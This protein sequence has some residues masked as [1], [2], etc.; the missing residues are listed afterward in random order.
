[1]CNTSFS[2]SL[3]AIFILSV[4]ETSRR[5]DTAISINGYSLIQNNT[6]VH[7]S[8]NFLLQNQNYS[9]FHH[10]RA[11]QSKAIYIIRNVQYLV[12]IVGCGSVLGSQPFLL[13]SESLHDCLML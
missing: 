11:M 1:M 3:I 13:L 6:F 9:T 5:V 8:T 7:Y 2:I 10:Q 12:I 4:G